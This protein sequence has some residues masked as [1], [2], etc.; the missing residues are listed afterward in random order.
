MRSRGKIL[1]AAGILF[2]FLI[3]LLSPV[4]MP[5]DSALSRKVCSFT[6]KVKE[7]VYTITHPYPELDY[8]SSD[9][10]D[11]AEASGGATRVPVLTYHSLVPA[12]YQPDPSNHSVMTVEEFE[13]QMDYLHEQGYYTA[14]LGE[15]EAF[16]HQA[17]SLPENTVVITFDDG[18]ENNYVYA[19]P[20]LQRYGFHAAI[21]LIGGSIREEAGEPFD[22]N[23]ISYLTRSQMAEAASVFEYHSHTYGLHHHITDEC[24]NTT[25]AVTDVTLLEQDIEDM[26]TAGFGTHY[27]AFPYGIYSDRAIRLLMSHDYRMGFTT[28]EGYVEHDSFTMRL[29]RFSISPGTDLSAILGE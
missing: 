3:L 8:P 21:F 18:Y 25:S 7:R 9:L 5:E 22:P 6:H 29:P 2:I 16:V 26:E 23:K 10:G 11:K 4:M 12:V 15:L 20:I 17:I 28:E 24:G 1:V 13:Q 27:F 14:T 19:Y